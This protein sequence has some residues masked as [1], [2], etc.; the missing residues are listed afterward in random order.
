MKKS[1]ITLGLLLLLT[2]CADKTIVTQVMTTHEYGFWGGLWHGVI[3]PFD[4]IASLIWDDVSVYAEHN[5]GNWYAFGFVLGMG[6][7]FGGS[8]TVS[9]SK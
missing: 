5:N 3:A 2:S 4:F 6:G 8:N 1:I 9:K 7:L